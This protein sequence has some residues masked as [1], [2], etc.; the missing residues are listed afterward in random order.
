M[1][2]NNL[3]LVRKKDYFLWKLESDIQE[4]EERAKPLE[5]APFDQ[6]DGLPREIERDLEGY[7][8]REFAVPPEVTKENNYDYREL[9]NNT[10]MN[11][12]R[13]FCEA[14]Q[15]AVEC[16]ITEDIGHMTGIC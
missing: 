7:V 5:V 8:R 11:Y 2:L 15:G 4:G 3:V 13:G 16:A 14:F 12:F 9:L 1:E 6:D 10:A